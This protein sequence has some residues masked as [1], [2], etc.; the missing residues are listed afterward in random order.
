MAQSTLV[1]RTSP[2]VAHYAP[3]HPRQRR[4]PPRRR[5]DRLAFYQNRPGTVGGRE[6]PPVFAQN[7]PQAQPTTT[8]KDAPLLYFANWSWQSEQADLV[9]WNAFL[10][11]LKSW[12]VTT[13]LTDVGWSRVEPA[14]GKFDF[15][16]Y[17]DRIQA[18]V[19][20]GLDVILIM[21]TG[22]ERAPDYKAQPAWVLK[23]YP[24]AQVQDFY[25]GNHGR[26]SFEHA[27]AMALF[28]DFIKT[29]SEHFVGQY[30][31]GIRAIGPN[32]SNQIETRYMQFEFKWLDYSAASQAGYRT[33]LKKKYGTIGKLNTA[34][35]SAFGSFDEIKMLVV[36]K[37]QSGFDPDIRPTYIDV[38]QYRQDSLVAGV[39]SSLAVIRAAGAKTYLH[40]GEVLTK[41]DAI[42]TLPMSDLA[43]SV[44]F[45]AVDY[46]HITG[47]GQPTDPS[48]VGFITSYAAQY[49]AKAI[50]EDSVESL[51]EPRFAKDRDAR[52][53]E[54]ITWAMSNGAAGIGVANFL[55][56]W[57]AQGVFKFQHAL[58]ATMQQR[59][60]V[61][62]RA[63]AVYGSIWLPF[64]YHGS[65][66]YRTSS[67]FRDVFQNN[68]HGMFKL[69]EGAGIPVG[70]LSDTAIAKGALK[71]YDVVVLPY[72]VVVP[73]ETLVAL[74]DW[75][76]AGGKLVQ[77]V[78]F[79]EFSLTGQRDE[80]KLGDMFNVTFGQARTDEV[81]TPTG[82]L[83]D[84][85]GVTSLTVGDSTLETNLSNGLFTTKLCNA[86]RPRTTSSAR[87]G[88]VRPWRST[89]GRGRPTSALCPAC[90]T[91]TRRTKRRWPRTKS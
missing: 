45:L 32:F 8:T 70:V 40:G 11:K 71:N 73:E 84:A 78:R 48:L 16:R 87:A 3:H 89:R 60:P 18:A 7:Q 4:G 63:V 37:N 31:T 59:K 82:A 25:G 69:L 29:A 88:R 39:E 64:G 2:P 62:E 41:D 86:G 14:E 83:A 55:S 38:M 75:Q 49:G 77:D 66:D 54:C 67:G 76:A 57:D 72:Q 53:N 35:S 22:V 6:L 68:V 79:G 46:N 30:H 47:D 9:S 80:A 50:F 15:K 56:E 19:D 23:K 90:S 74:R 21:D 33:W 5:R 61:S 51:A 36:D 91:C 65:Q 81:A 24:D 10:D 43:P 20:H 27:K 17:D 28:N 52:V 44:D 26:I 12:G 85:L 13:V 1:C 42:F 34:W 58:S